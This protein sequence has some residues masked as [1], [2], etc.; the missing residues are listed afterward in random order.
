MHCPCVTYSAVL[1]VFFKVPVRPSK[2]KRP[3][4]RHGELT[5]FLHAMISGIPSPSRS[6]TMGVVMLLTPGQEKSSCMEKALL[7][8]GNVQ[9]ADVT[10][11]G[12]DVTVCALKLR[13]NRSITTKAQNANVNRAISRRTIDIIMLLLSLIIIDYTLCAAGMPHLLVSRLSCSSPQ[14]SSLQL[15]RLVHIFKHL[16]FQPQT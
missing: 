11:S 1:I 3:A 5:L 9:E 2:T 10:L 13:A 12:Y 14:R 16:V 7:S 4:E 6:A 15:R 8:A